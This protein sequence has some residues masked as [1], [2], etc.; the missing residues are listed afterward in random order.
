M[1]H[2]FPFKGWKNKPFFIRLR[3][4]EYWPMQ[5]VY[6]PGFLY[7]VWLSLKARSFWFF[8][9]ANPSIETGGMLGEKKFPLIEMLPSHVKP[10]SLLVPHGMKKDEFMKLIGTHGFSYPFIL[11][12]DVGERG[13]LVTKVTDEKVLNQ[14]LAANKVDFI[15]QEYVHFPVEAG[16]LYYRYPNEERGQITSLVLKEFLSVTGDGVSTLQ[17]LIGK[18]PRAILQW[19]KFQKRF[20]DRLNEVLPEGVRLELEA[21]GNH[22]QGTKFIN[23]N[24]YI[25]EDL[26]KVFD[27]ITSSMPGVYYCRY[28]IRTS[29]IE[30]MKKGENIRIIEINGVGADPAHIYDPSY[31]IFSAWKDYFRCWKAIYGIAK[32]NH[33]NGAPYMSTKETMQRIKQLK[34]YRKLAVS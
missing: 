32:M 5:V 6:T 1:S 22:A 34:A 21:I 11:K 2:K 31:S 14:Y 7:Y 17:E 25:D 4:W 12:P 23:G 3:S 16:V 10:K 30:E 9:A 13:F 8:S 18:N 27:E 19:N 29:S 15:V 28:D 20:G 26:V 33:K 24:K